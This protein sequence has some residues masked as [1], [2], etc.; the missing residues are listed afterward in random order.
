[1]NQDEIINESLKDHLMEVFEHHGMLVD[2]DDSGSGGG[3]G[4]TMNLDA[5]FCAWPWEHMFSMLDALSVD[6]PPVA[7]VFMGG[8]MDGVAGGSSSN[9]YQFRT[10]DNE[11]MYEEREVDAD[12][13]DIEPVF[14][15]Y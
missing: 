13:D 10:D 6:C 1:M 9:H 15:I 8:S 12:A 5:F 14:D 7:D 11:G 2:A 4:R 3:T